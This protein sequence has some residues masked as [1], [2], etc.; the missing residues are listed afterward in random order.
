MGNLKHRRAH[1]RATPP[2]WA[3]YCVL[4]MHMDGTDAST[5]F[6][7]EK[8]HTMTANGNAQIDTAQ[9]VFGTGSGL[10]D[11]SSDYIDVAHSSDWDFGSGD[12]T[13]DFRL[14]IN[15]IPE[16]NCIYL[17]TASSGNYSPLFISIRTDGRLRLATSTNGTSWTTGP[18]DSDAVMTTGQWYHIAVVRYGSDI[19]GYVNGVLKVTLSSVGTLV[20]SP[21]P[22]HIGAY[23]Y[24]GGTIASLD[25]W[26]DEFRILK[27][28]A[29]WTANFTPP[30]SAYSL[31]SS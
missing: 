9:K 25:G 7:D 14:K 17:Q 2:A 12:F 5:I 26:L 30:T 21:N 22:L 24:S 19:K 6:T 20:D 28:Y 3:P 18:T 31:T 16:D 4:L 8:G 29:A 1:F 13:V 10:F 15:S 11:G 27:G 23:V